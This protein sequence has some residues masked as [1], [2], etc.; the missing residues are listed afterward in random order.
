ML[1]HTVRSD[2]GRMVYYVDTGRELR[3]QPGCRDLRVPSLALF[4][5]RSTTQ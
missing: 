4:P 5:F 3:E 2:G 1:E